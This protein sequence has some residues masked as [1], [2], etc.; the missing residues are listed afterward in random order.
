MP[1]L[2]VQRG[3][4]NLESDIFETANQPSHVQNGNLIDG[5]KGHSYCALSGAPQRQLTCRF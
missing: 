2:H 4:H 1:I 5:A 3:L